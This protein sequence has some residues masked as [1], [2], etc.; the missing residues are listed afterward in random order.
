MKRI[1]AVAATLAITAAAALVT[2]A[3]AM[4]TSCIYQTN[5]SF[6]TTEFNNWY[7][8]ARWGDSLD[9]V[10]NVYAGCG[11]NWESGQ[12]DWNGHYTQVRVWP[13][14]DG[15]VTEITFAHFTLAPNWRAH[16]TAETHS[17]TWTY[18]QLVCE[19]P[20]DNN[21]PCTPINP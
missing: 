3:P 14:N 6:T 7:D 19:W 12:G 1:A 8:G 2:A 13:R 18:N 16:D 21:A 4:A 20:R 17:G 15:G 9:H 5:G 10:E 11:G